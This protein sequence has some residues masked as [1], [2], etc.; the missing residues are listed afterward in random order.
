MRNSFGPTNPPSARNTGP[1]E[2]RQIVEPHIPNAGPVTAV[3]NVLLQSSLI[4][5]KAAGFYERYER[6]VA[7]EVLAELTANLGPSWIPIETVLAHYDACDRMNLSEADF[8]KLGA[9]VGDRVHSTVLVT[10]KKKPAEDF[11]LWKVEG[12]LHRMWGRVFQGGSIQVV[13][14]GP[15]LKLVETR[16]MRLNR[17]HYYRQGH[18][19]ALRATHIALGVDVTVMRVESYD[20]VID[21]M[22]VRVAWL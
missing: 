1:H 2:I 19:A 21:E 8:A 15:K 18:L 9:R 22:V 5:L 12:P 6:L 20:D 13:K 10:T 3:R 14:L 17:Y 11:D 4:E 16:G 7:P